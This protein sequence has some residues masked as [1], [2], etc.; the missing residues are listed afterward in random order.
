[1]NFQKLIRSP[2]R[3]WKYVLCLFCFIHMLSYFKQNMDVDLVQKLRS[4]FT[5]TEPSLL[6]Y[7]PNRYNRKS[8]TEDVCVDITGRIF[9]TGIDSCKLFNKL[10][11]IKASCILT[12]ACLFNTS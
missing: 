3:F 10:K 6:E 4:Y 2:V 11:V 5:Q 12:L 7:C 1:M 9:N 8:C